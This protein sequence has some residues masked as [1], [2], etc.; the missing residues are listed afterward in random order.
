VQVAAGPLSHRGIRES[1]G[2]LHACVSEAL[3]LRPPLIFLMRTAMVDMD[4]QARLHT[5]PCTQAHK[6]AVHAGPGGLP[7]CLL[8]LQGGAAG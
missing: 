4:V 7:E 3:R 1:M 8:P 5:P 2:L 6:H